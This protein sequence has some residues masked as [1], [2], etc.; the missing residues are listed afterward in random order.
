MSKITVKFPDS[1]TKE[2]KS[3][4]TCLEIVKSISNSL[5]KKVLVVS[6]L[7]ILVWAVTVQERKIFH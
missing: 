7:V 3:G 6:P 1:S 5:A 4:I 2:F